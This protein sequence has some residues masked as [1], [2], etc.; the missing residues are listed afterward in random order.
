MEEQRD[1]VT[2]P[3]ADEPVQLGPMTMAR[4]KVYPRLVNGR[5][6]RVRFIISAFL[7]VILFFGPW[8]MYDGQQ[9]IQIDLAARRFHFFWLTF[10]PQDTYFLLVILIFLAV[11]LFASTAVGGRMWCG[12]ACPQ[13]LLTESFIYVEAFFEGDRMRRMRRDRGRWTPDKIARKMGKW[14][15][16][17]LMSLWLG[18]TVAGY[19]QDSYQL[20]FELMDGA[21]SS[22]TATLIV[23]VAAAAYFDF[24]WFREQFCHYACPYARFQGAMFDPDS[25]IISYDRKRGEP[26]GKAKDAKAGD[27]VDCQIC[28]QVC[29]SGIDI[30]NGLQLECIACTAC[31]DACDGVMDRLKRPRGL[32]G[33]TSLN[34]LEGEA[35][36]VVR[37]R[38]VIYAIILFALGILFSY[39]MANRPLLVFDVIRK[40][41]ITAVYTVT[42]DGHVSNMYHLNIINKDRQPHTLQ[43]SLEDFPD[44]QLVAPQNPLPMERESARDFDIFVIHPPRGLPV[45]KQFRIKV[46]DLVDPRYTE[47]QE[48]SFIGPAR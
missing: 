18:I 25:L 2:A 10:W 27:C 1:R 46:Q 12:Y 4:R 13:T 14:T 31:I 34:Q 36:S 32:V 28:V 9:A 45:V 30:R 41:G 5:F 42:A 47:V 40:S 20:L 39:M 38:V 22:G 48:I 33:Y 3:P 29:P 26:R 16:W 35:H 21:V 37:P 11:F 8:L 7:Q 19:F 15:I 43:I 24:G 44:A 23:V 6:R 17:G